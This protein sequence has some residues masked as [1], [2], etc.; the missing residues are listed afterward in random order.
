MAE[1]QKTQPDLQDVLSGLKRNIGIEINCHKI[2]KI[3]AYNKERNVV[4][5]EL[6]DKMMLN[7][8]EKERSLLI[9]V[10]LLILQGGNGSLTF[11]N[12]VNNYCLVL[13]NDRDID[14]WFYS[15]AVSVPQSERTHHIMDGIA[16]VGLHSLA[17]PLQDYDSSAT[18][19]RKGSAKITIKDNLIKIDNGAGSVINVNGESVSI[20][21]TTATIQANSLSINAPI[22]S[23]SGNVT[24]TGTLVADNGAV[25]MADGNMTTSGDVIAS[26]KSLVTHKHPYSWTSGAGSSNTGSPS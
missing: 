1:I 8:E 9:E 15:G 16:I 22:S 11:P 25:T 13:F 14:N 17:N 4:E 18:T 19:L 23:F 5:V 3:T 20:V 24:I 6:M 21:T 26:G 2:G 10:P 12:P 7:G